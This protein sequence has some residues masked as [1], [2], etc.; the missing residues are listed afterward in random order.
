MLG[1]MRR[2]RDGRCGDLPGLSGK[3]H[4]FLRFRNCRIFCIYEWLVAGYIYDSQ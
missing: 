2:D 1:S 4:D 3:K